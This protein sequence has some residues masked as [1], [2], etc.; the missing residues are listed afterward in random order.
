M[1]GLDI[2]SEH[3]EANSDTHDRTA[4]VPRLCQRGQLRK[5]FHKAT[6]QYS[7]GLGMSVYLNTVIS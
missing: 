6:L 5:C 4:T 2:F 3:S 7:H 1:S